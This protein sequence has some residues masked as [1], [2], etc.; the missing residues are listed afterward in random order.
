M[1]GAGG[2]FKRGEP[3]LMGGEGDP[4]RTSL[5]FVREGSPSPPAAKGSAREAR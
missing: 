3:L 5:Q 2:I 4:E 1:N